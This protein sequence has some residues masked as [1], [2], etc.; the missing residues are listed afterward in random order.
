MSDAMVWWCGCIVAADGRVT[1]CDA[2]R[3]HYDAD[4]RRAIPRAECP[5]C[6]RLIGTYKDGTIRPHAHTVASEG[7]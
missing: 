6:H 2:H 1:P 3:D 5:Q 7:D 4:G